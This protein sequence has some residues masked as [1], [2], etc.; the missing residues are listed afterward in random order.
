MPTARSTVLSGWAAVAVAAAPC[1]ASAQ[2]S[3]EVAASLEARHEFVSVI[4]GQRYAA[5][6]ITQALLGAHYRDL[7]TSPIQVPVLDLERYAGGLTVKELGGGQQTTSLHLDS[8]D[9][10]EFTFR[11]LDKDPSP[12]LPKPFRGTVVN[13]LVQDA[14]SAMNPAGALIAAS[15]LEAAGV[16]HAEPRLAVMPDD[17]RLGEH[18]KTFAGMLGIIELRPGDG[19]AGAAEVVDSKDLLERLRE[20]SDH[21]VDAAAFL[22]ARLVDHLMG[23]WDRHEDQWRFLYCF[24]HIAEV[25]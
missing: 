19:F 16:L 15:L 4:A 18:R 20:S 3:S 24:G 17:E 8:G 9:G 21:R 23:D 12:A 1:V 11:S 6:D 25:A 5:G 10:R 14:T 13:G 22:T 2:G 7:W